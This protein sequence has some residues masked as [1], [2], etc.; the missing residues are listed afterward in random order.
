MLKMHKNKRLKSIIY[1]NYS[2]YENSGKILDF[3]IENFGKVFLFSLG[4]HHLGK[5]KQYNRLLIYINGK[6]YEQK[7]LIQIPIGKKFIF[8]LL[9]LKS[10]ITFVQMLTYSFW[11]KNKYGKVNFYFTVNAFTAWIGTIVKRMGFADKTI[12][13]VWDYYPPFHENKIIR[14]MRYIYWQFDKISSHSDYVAYVNQRLIDLRKDMGVLPKDARFTI[15]PIGTDSF[16]VELQTKKDVVFG[17]IGVL[18]KSHGLD[19]IF[20]NASEIMKHFPSARFEVIGSGPDEKYF[21]R[22]AKNLPIPT[23]F[24]GYLKEKAFNNVLRK[25]SI[26]IAAYVPD[27][28][29]VS[30]FGDPGKIKRYLSLGIPAILTNV[31]EFSK[32]VENARAGV[33]VDY[34]N[35][36]A[37]IQA[38][39]RIMFNYVQYSENALKLSSRFYYKDIYPLM[40]KSLVL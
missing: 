36:P 20:N 38:I 19:I 17:F 40:F 29:N 10:L 22:K 11:L 15:V 21:R 5:K 39:K 8:F 35:S 31:I 28:S 23:K 2:P 6:L 12:F 27:K 26:G 14:L 1:V 33:I 13:W 37:F 3:L 30:H 16:D 7:S 9:P 4:F 24:Y 32:E 34:N 25:C 18:K